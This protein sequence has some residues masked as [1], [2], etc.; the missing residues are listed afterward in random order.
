MANRITARRARSTRSHRLRQKGKRTKRARDHYCY[1][2]AANI[3]KIFHD[4]E[5]DFCFFF[6]DFFTFKT[7]L[8]YHQR[9]Y[10]ESNRYWLP[11]APSRFDAFSMAI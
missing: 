10:W 6:S 1:A 11:V 3:P 4:T 8:W 2:C 9:A 5:I 7:D